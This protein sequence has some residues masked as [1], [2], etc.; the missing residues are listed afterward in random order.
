MN[1]A[2]GLIREVMASSGRDYEIINTE[3]PA[4]ATE[5]ARQAVGAGASA[6]VAVGGDGTLQETAQG[7]AGTDMPMG[8][9]PVGN[10][11]DFARTY[12]LNRGL[13]APKSFEDTVRWYARRALVCRPEPVDAIK[14]G[15]FVC[16]NIGGVG[17]DA[18]IAREGALMKRVFGKMSYIVSTVK[19]AVTFKPFSGR[20]VCDGNVFEGE[21]TLVS[22]CNGQ[23]YG[24]GFRIA[25]NA[26]IN[27]GK[28]TAVVIRKMPNVKV[29][30]L[31]PSVLLGRHEGIS[32][33]TM[34]EAERVEVFFEGILHVNFDGNIFSLKS[35]L[36]FEVLP[37]AVKLF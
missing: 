30:A 12:A 8:I 5:L 35:P 22:V 36:K 33:V 21:F 26:A 13:A 11:N 25:P 18:D 16:L 28:L 3:K 34:L 37:G 17:L 10:G 15:G 19:N 29:L 2:A 32:Q 6:V 27:D 24:G 7:I 23:Y 20:V 31:F 14:A 9:I 1:E 4:H